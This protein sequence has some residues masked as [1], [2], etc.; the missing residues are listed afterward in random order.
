MAEVVI[1]WSTA[2][3]QEVAHTLAETLVTECLAA[4]VHVLPQ[5][6]SFYRWQGALNR[7]DEHLLMIKT[8]AGRV[9]ALQKRLAEQHPYEVPE[10]LSVPV[11]E[12]LPDYLAW[13]NES[14][15]EV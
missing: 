7:D 15:D 10:I 11:A 2:P 4:C 6:L 8:T 9:E 14:V 1:V 5:G 13:V 12:G 3:D